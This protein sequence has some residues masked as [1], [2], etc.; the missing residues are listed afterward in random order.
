MKEFVSLS[1]YTHMLMF[2]VSAMAVFR[3][4]SAS[5]GLEIASRMGA[6]WGS[7]VAN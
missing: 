6:G 3:E 2:G 1:H 7:Y 4:T 5:D